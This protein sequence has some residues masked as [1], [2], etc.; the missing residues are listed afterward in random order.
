M[1][2]QAGVT[3][4][5]PIWDDVPAWYFWLSHAPGAY[6]LQLERARIEDHNGAANYHGLFSIKV[7]PFCTDPVF[8]T[9]SFLERSLVESYHLDESNTPRFESRLLIPAAL[10]VVGTLEVICNP[11]DQWTLLTVEALETDLAVYKDQ[12]LERYDLISSE[13]AYSAGDVAR[14]VPAWKI[15]HRLFDSMVSLFSFAAK[16][17]PKRVI[18]SQSPGFERVFT[19]REG[20]KC[21]QT[22]DIRLMCMKVLLASDASLTNFSEKLIVNGSDKKEKVLYD[23]S[24]EIRHAKSMSFNA[25]TAGYVNPNWWSIARED[26]KSHLSSL[27]GC[28]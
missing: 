11:E 24:P 16:H 22:S 10:F 13:Y 5:S 20:W 21:A 25:S 1:R 12:I 28:H 3:G 8:S 23:N 17:G 18:L 27:C 9:F 15:S 6:Q 26:C 4:V 19:G 2:E 14:Q 7:F